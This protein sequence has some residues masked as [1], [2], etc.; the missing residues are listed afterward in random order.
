MRARLSRALDVLAI[1]LLA[2][3]LVAAVPQ[4]MLRALGMLRLAKQAAHESDEAAR[5]RAY[6]EDYTRAIDEIRRAIPASGGYLLVEGG[7]PQDGGVYWVRY[8]LAP[9]R[10]VY[11]GHL[12]ELTD[13]RRLRKR[14]G[15][16]LRQVVVAYGPGLAPRLYERYRFVNEIERRAA[17]ATG[18]GSGAARSPGGPTPGEREPGAGPPRSGAPGG[19]TPATAAPVGDGR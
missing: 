8:D 10:A 2:F 19:R 17:A 3:F 14:I 15:A 13:A 9:R 11:L 1:G 6:G 5:A 12:S 18:A 4:A 7:R 16:N